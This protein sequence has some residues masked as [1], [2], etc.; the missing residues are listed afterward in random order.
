[1]FWPCFRFTWEYEFRDAYVCNHQTG[2][3]QFSAPF[4]ERTRELHYFRMSPKFFIEFPELKADIQQTPP[5]PD[6]GST[7]FEEGGNGDFNMESSQGMESLPNPFIEAEGLCQH[8]L[9]W[10]STEH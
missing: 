3:Y 7:D 4:L 10:E 5:Q 8:G 9:A 1:M 6:I 2:H